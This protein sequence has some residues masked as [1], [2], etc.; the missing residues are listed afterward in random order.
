M[1]RAMQHDADLLHA[2]LCRNVLSVNAVKTGYL[3]FGNAKNL[4]DINVSIDGQSINRVSYYKYLGL[5]IDEELT[6]SND[7]VKKQ[8][9]PFISLMWRKSKYIPVERRKEIYYA[10]VQSH[11]LYMSAIYG[12]CPAYKIKELQTI[13]NRCVKAL[14]RL[15]R[16]TSST[17][18]YSTGIL[19]FT[20][21]VKVERITTIHKLVH[22]LT[23]HNF[24]LATNASIHG[25]GTRNVNN[26]HIFNRMSSRNTSNAA[27]ERAFNEYNN[28]DIATR[29][30]TCLRTFKARV[31]LKVLERSLK[32]NVISAYLFIN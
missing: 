8:L 19:P 27:L 10:Y 24:P 20:E 29:H 23:K 32:F 3:P 30:L 13:Q 2:W 1:Q 17:Y 26:L 14:F 7:P 21:L 18:L 28:I 15:P 5:I 12:E 25:F 16:Y 6:F 4:P 31:R 22:S 9:T 11:L